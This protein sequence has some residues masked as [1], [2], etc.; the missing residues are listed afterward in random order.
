[1]W[2][3]FKI[4]GIGPPILWNTINP[5]WSEFN[6]SQYSR[7]I[8]ALNLILRDF[9]ELMVRLQYSGDML[10]TRIFVFLNCIISCYRFGLPFYSYNLLLLVILLI[11]DISSVCL[12]EPPDRFRRKLRRLL[13]ILQTSNSFHT[14]SKSLHSLTFWQLGLRH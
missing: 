14:R 11:F 13:E 2:R 12:G 9:Y 7:V 4:I 6:S 8:R 5:I 10:S 1:M 3:L